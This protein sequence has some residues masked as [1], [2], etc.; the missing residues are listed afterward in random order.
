MAEDSVSITTDRLLL[1]PVRS[2]DAEA[3]AAV[4]NDRRIARNMT[5]AFPHPYTRSDA[6]SFIASSVADYA[7]TVRADP[8][9]HVIGMV[10]S[11]TRTSDD[12]GVAIF[13]YWL[14][15]DYWGQGYATEAA[16]A[17]L[18]RLSAQ[19]GLRRIEAAVYGWNPASGRV[20]EK[21][22]LALEGRHPARV[23]RFGE[24]TDELVYGL[25]L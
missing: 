4:A 22:G 6:E 12:P 1:R 16:R 7:I 19:P 14:G 10:G 18:D 3:L 2:S 9:E 13:G 24:V 25:V 17:Y 20:L 21:V 11:S 15:V 8:D 5:A 23:C